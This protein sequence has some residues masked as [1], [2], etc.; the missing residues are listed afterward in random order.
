[1]SILYTFYMHILTDIDTCLCS[2]LVY[3]L[4]HL[5]HI[6]RDRRGVSWSTGACSDASPWSPPTLPPLWRFMVTLAVLAT[7]FVSLT[8]NPRDAIVD[9]II[10]ALDA[11]IYTKILGRHLQA[12][13]SSQVESTRDMTIKLK[14]LRFHLHS[15]SSQY[16]HFGVGF[17]GLLVCHGAKLGQTRA[18]GS[19]HSDAANLWCKPQRRRKTWRIC[20]DIETAR[21]GL[22][23]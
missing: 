14:L 2:S 3:L 23:N 15:K 8:F 7:L 11:G 5:P 12:S 21:F 9:S 22:L 20:R 18:L 4:S 1:M 10:V 19:K 13:C 16:K 6:D 17:M